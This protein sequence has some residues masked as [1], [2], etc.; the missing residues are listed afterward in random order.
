MNEAEMDRACSIHR[1]MLNEYN[2]LAENSR[3]KR[4]FVR[5]RRRI[6]II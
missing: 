1:E 3:G 2:I 6:K 5:L 4:L